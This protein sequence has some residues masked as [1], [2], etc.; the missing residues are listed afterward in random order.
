M[1]TQLHSTQWGI[2]CPCECFDPAT[3]ILMWDGTIKEAREIVVGDQLIDDNGNA[4]RV[5][6]TCSG[7][8]SMYEV[9]PDRDNFMSHTVTDN[10]ILTLKVKGYGTRWGEM[11]LAW[12][13]KE[14]LK[15]FRALLDDDDVVDITIEQYLSLPEYIQKSLCI[16]KSAG[17]NWERKDVALDPY[18]LGMWLGDGDSTGYGFATADAELLA[19]WT[20]WGAEHDATILQ[21]SGNKYHYYIRTQTGNPCHKT[22][23]APLKKLLA[24]YE[25]IKNKH[26]P[27]D[28]LVNDRATRLA[29]LA[30]LVDTDGH[31]SHDGH[32]IRIAQGEKNYRIIHDA[33]FLARSL[34]FSCRMKDR[35][36]SY[37]Y[38]GE[39][40][41][42]PCKELA[43]TGAKLYEIPTVLP[44]KVMRSDNP[45]KEHNWNSPFKLMKKD[46]QPFVGWQLEGNG[47]FLLGDMSVSHNTPEVGQL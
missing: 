37:T 4:V 36:F 43:I 26:I 31:V 12:F 33:E 21:S 25:L 16:F 30:G 44:R 18:I 47:R 22:E 6:S 23:Q 8:K 14:E 7:I 9:V 11:R 28:Y 3:P 40:L 32:R 38:K 42:R 1:H 13:D 19:H 41:F 27:R 34:G 17:I 45:V 20:E 24:K 39:K 5:K 29:V 46:V 10:H 15:A 35:I 2:V